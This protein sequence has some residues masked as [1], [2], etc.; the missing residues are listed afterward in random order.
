MQTIVRLRSQRTR[1]GVRSER[2][3]SAVEFILV[4]PIFIL[5]IIGLMEFSLA[6]NALIGVNFASRDAALLAAEAAAD[7]GADCVI[8]K[9]VESD[10]NAPADRDRITEVRV[11]WATDTGAMM[12]GN[13]V[14]VYRRTGSTTCTTPGG[15]IITVPYSLVGVA[16]Y[17]VS[18]R[19]DVIGGCGGSHDTVDTIAVQIRYTHVWAT[20]LAR[21]VSLGG[22]GFSFEHTNAMRM[23]PSL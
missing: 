2:G 19:C 16:G 15:S 20:P 10:I 3:Q 5:I 21:L 23:E 9:S 17:P 14:N 22:T 8:L 11:Y 7:A 4:F 18:I 13:P 6:F 12:P 1:D